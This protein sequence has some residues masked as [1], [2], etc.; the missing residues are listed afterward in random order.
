MEKVLTRN[1]GP[2]LQPTDLKAYEA[3]G[4]YQG[5]R[6]A[7]AESSPKDCLDVI[8]AANLR[9]RGGAGFPTGVAILT[10]AAHNFLCSVTLVTPMGK[11][12]SLYIYL[13]KS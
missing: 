10:L 11:K 1:I 2:D 3:N 8:S 6:K 4:G 9:G 12:V 5:L 13:G 7:L